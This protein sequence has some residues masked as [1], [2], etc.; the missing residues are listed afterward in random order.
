[1]A[2]PKNNSAA[3]RHRT[4][5]LSP[6]AMRRLDRW[7]GLPLCLLASIAVRLSGLFPRRAVVLPRRVLYVALAEMGSIVLAA[8][9]IRQNT[10]TYGAIP[11]FVTLAQTRGVFDFLGGEF[12]REVHILRTTSLTA[13]CADLWS[14]CWHMR[15]SGIAVAID[16]DPGSRFSALV[17]LLSGARQRSGFGGSGQPYRGSL[18]THSVECPAAKHMSE[19]FAALIQAPFDGIGKTTTTVVGLPYPATD[20]T[21]AAE[22]GRVLD[23]LRERVPHCDLRRQRIVLIHANRSDP[24]PQRRW[25]RQR[26]I[27]LCRRLLAEWPDVLLLF[28]GA[29]S[30]IEHA[31]ALCAE[32]DDTRCAS[33]AGSLSVGELPALFALA[34]LLVSSD[35]GP[36]HLAAHAGVPVVALFGPETPR[37]YR[38]LG[39]TVTLYA[40]LP[41]SPCLSA[42]NQRTSSCRDAKCMT[43]IDIEAV[44]DATRDI[45][46]PAEQAVM[47]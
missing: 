35:S 36:A 14:L 41:C 17:A 44:L 39:A 11:V 37:R 9:A 15:R 23:R 30:E 29:T 2:N 21:Q 28:I 19:N 24:V 20:S 7:I 33:V 10:R 3:M 31:E 25:P 12:A 34:T 1:M 13:L 16:L 22:S 47:A 27:H 32:I 18:Y 45:L 38:P 4:G 6:Q 40:G 5:T 26:Y 42:S 43:A 8:P 46:A